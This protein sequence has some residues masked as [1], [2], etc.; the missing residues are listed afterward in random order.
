M[1]EDGAYTL[2]GSTNPGVRSPSA[3][4]ALCSEDEWYKA[5]YYVPA[6][7]GKGTYRLFSLFGTVVKHPPDQESAYGVAEMADS[8]WEW[9]ESKVGELFRGLRSC[10]WFLGNNR[11]AAGRFFINPTLE[12]PDI[13][14]RVVKR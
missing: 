4:Y 1:V 2:K 13:G 3:K 11:Q 9:N 5:A 7:S 14:F 12:L 10:A 8:V 6:A